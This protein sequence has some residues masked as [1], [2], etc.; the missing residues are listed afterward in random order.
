MNLSSVDAF[1]FAPPRDPAAAPALVATYE[2]DPAATRPGL[3]PARFASVRP[4]D[5]QGDMVTGFEPG[6]DVLLGGLALR[7][8]A[9]ARAGS[10][11]RDVLI[12]N[13]RAGAR[14]GG[15]P[16]AQRGGGCAG[17]DRGTS[18]SGSSVCA[19]EEGRERE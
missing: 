8:V 4:G 9:R 11:Q 2:S 5:V 14:A 1:L 7:L 13:R 10:V 15:G 17:C 19:R 6:A 12:R 16:R 18:R 3:S